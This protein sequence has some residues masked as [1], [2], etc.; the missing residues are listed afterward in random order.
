MGD[1]TVKRTLLT[2]ACSLILAV[3]VGSAWAAEPAWE[4]SCPADN[5]KK[6]E[7]RGGKF[8]KWD[9]TCKIEYTTKER[10]NK[11][12]SAVVKHTITFEKDKWDNCKREESKKIVAC[13]NTKK[14][15]WVDEKKCKKCLK[16]DDKDDD[17]KDKDDKDY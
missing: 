6:C 4:R 16:D 3:A 5:K 15:K 2:F 9:K 12:F 10:C 17:D 14:N 11:K 7:D 13:K 1:F 8:N